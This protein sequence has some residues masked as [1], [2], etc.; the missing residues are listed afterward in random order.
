MQP[1]LSF[2]V[3]ESEPPQARDKRRRS[4]GKSSGETYVETLRALAPDARCH[5]VK[6]ADAPSELPTGAALAGYDSVFVTGSPL[7][8]YDDSPETRREVEFMRA[9]FAAGTPAFGSCAGLQVATVAAGGTVRRAQNGREAAFAR[10]ITPIRVGRTHPLLAGRPAV[11]DAP[12]FHTDEVEHLPEGAVL[13]ATNTLTKVQAA[14]IRQGDGVFWGVQYHPELGLDE[15]AG[16]LRRQSEELI[17]EG[18]ART[19]TDVEDY[20]AE[21]EVLHREP[22]RR[23]LAWRLGLDQEVTEPSRRVVE[24]R[25]F[26]EQLARPHRSVRGRA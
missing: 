6:P 1:P 24:I 18:L 23:D 14:E 7:H 21:L 26:I 5:R 10:R 17:R 8:A 2:L 9:V 15:V 25:N 22:A 19:E 13:L 12:A 11:Y 3:A 4:V 20:A 16:A